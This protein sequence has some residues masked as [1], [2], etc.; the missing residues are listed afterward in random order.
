MKL[1]C[2]GLDGATFRV[3]KPLCDEGKLPTLG[4][5]L[6]N[7]VHGVLESTF[8]PVT[9]PAWSAMATGKN[10]GK[11]AIFDSIIRK[12]KDSFETRM[13]NSFDIRR[14]RPYWDYLSSA[15]F[16]VG[17][18]NY[19]FLYPP[20]EINGIIVSGLGSSPDDE[21]CYPRDFKQRLV[22]KCG[23]YRIHLPSLQPQYTKNPL[24]L[25]KDVFEL[26]EINN[27]TLQLVLEEDLQFLTFVISAGDFV[28]H[29]MW[30][31]IDPQHPYYRED[32]AK[33]YR[34]K[35]IQVW[36]RIDEIL[37]LVIDR[38]SQD[39]NIVIVSDHGFGPHRSD[40]YTNSW[41]KEEGYLIRRGK[42]I[43]KARQ[44]QDA[45]AQWI[46]K[47]SPYLFRKLIRAT[48]LGKIPYI[49]EMSELDLERSLAFSPVNAS[50]V[51][52]IHINDKRIPFISPGKDLGSIRDEIMKK[53]ADACFNLGLSVKVYSPDE[54]YT[55]K[56]V[57]LA[58][59]ILFE[60]G[61]GECSIRY[62]FATPPFQ[63]PPPDLT[64]SGIHQKDGIF[65][66]CGPDIKQGIE[67]DRAKIYDIAP[68][69]LHMLGS[70]VPDDMDGRVLREIFRDG[71]EP[72]QREVKYQPVDMERAKVRKKIKELRALGNI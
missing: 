10:P 18:I 17:V 29:Y 60:I 38:L 45:V 24:L 63:E 65:I 64:F 35:F 28:Q 30:Q 6:E 54:L 7:G 8:P 47:V 59:D 53:L 27:K 11:T 62:S 37:G 32:E 48:N 70:P 71:S 1:I 26:L 55:G 46:K 72:A 61:N 69:I 36:Q 13:M 9:G 16:R 4:H 31:Y 14:V 23:K 22:K 12:S 44:L 58:P 68:T 33:E 2:I 42:S 57:A 66:G 43:T 56:Y 34:P 50:G 21:I 67:I 41:L 5:L 51:G 49:S 19:P 39:G 20:Y 3:I 52:K 15:G 25:V 40:F